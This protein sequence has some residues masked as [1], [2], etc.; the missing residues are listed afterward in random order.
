M[1]LLQ[2][3]QVYPTIPSKLA[4]LETLARNYWWSWQR[5]AV[6]LFRRIDP[7]LWAASG[8]NPLVFLT[9]VSQNRLENLAG[10]H[11]FM[12][13]LDQ[14]RERFEKRV[15]APVEN[16]S[17]PLGPDNCVAYFSMEFGIHESLPLYSGGLGILAGDHLKAASAVDLP[18][19][20]VGLLYRQGY[21]HQWSA[22]SR[23]PFWTPT[24]RKT[25]PGCAT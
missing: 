18:L 24:C 21:F 17:P 8:E 23:F 1:G 14:V 16:A 15:L 10:D 22:A 4:F 5:D 6:D 9:R 25:P 19:V 20:G 3:F 12:G 7:R 2:T 13:H 11:S